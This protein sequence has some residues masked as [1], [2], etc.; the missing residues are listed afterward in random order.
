LKWEANE[1]F[2]KKINPV[3]SHVNVLSDHAP[4]K[5]PKFVSWNV[6]AQR[7][8]VKK[9]SGE[10][11]STAKFEDLVEAV[12]P[13]GLAHDYVFESDELLKQ[14]RMAQVLAINKM[15]TDMG[16]NFH[17]VFLQQAD[18]ELMTML[19]EHL[20]Y[21]NAPVANKHHCWVYYDAN[22]SKSNIIV[23]SL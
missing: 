14:R 8:V 9:A 18:V 10:V 5:N 1:K 11:V 13:A 21:T 6:Q 4:V 15:I 20:C 23:Y 2:D 3:Q 12:G 7:K 16:P 22:Q 19:G 17:A